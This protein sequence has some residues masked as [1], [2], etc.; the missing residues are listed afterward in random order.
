MTTWIDGFLEQ[1]EEL[2]GREVARSTHATHFELGGGVRRAVITAAPQHFRSAQGWQAYD[3]GLRQDAAARWGAPGAAVRL[4]PDG[5]LS[6]SEGSAYQ[7]RTRSVGVLADGEYTPLAQLPDGRAV[8]SSLRRETGVFCHELTLTEHGVKE[9]LILSAA[10]DGVERSGYLVYETVH[11]GNAQGLLFSPGSAVDA[12]GRFFAV[13]HFSVEGTEFTGLAME[14]VARASFP[15]VIDPSVF[16][17]AVSDGNIAGYATNYYVARSTSVSYDVG[18]ADMYIGQAYES[19]IPRYYAFRS[20]LKFSLASLNLLA[21]IYAANLHLACMGDSSA[22]AD[23]DLQ[24]VKQ[25]WAPQDPLSNGNR[26]AA[27]DGCLAGAAD[28]VWR[29]TSGLSTGV[30]LPSPPLDISWLAPGATAY[31]SLR[32]SRDAAGNLPPANGNEY[33]RLASGLH[34]T[35]AMRPALVVDYF[36]VPSA[37]GTLVQPSPRVRLQDA[38]IKLRARRRKTLLAAERITGG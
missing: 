26:E 33:V 29:N 32:S 36:A 37:T 19:A 10:P 27:Y 2:A 6:F 3:L 11:R 4:A 23:F 35:L 8:G 9:S 31:Y 15:L 7:Q 17:G 25:N 1:N 34:G 12:E 16:F 22:L 30:L 18:T 28:A 14:D 5:T 21:E 20:L 38:R 13:H 24:I